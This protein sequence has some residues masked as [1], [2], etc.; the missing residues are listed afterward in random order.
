MV[1]AHCAL[2][3]SLT[4]VALWGRRA[5]A[6]QTLAQTLR[7]EGLPVEAAF[8]L[9]E[10]VQAAD[11]VC[12]ATTSTV[13]IVR[14]AW[15]RDGTH[16]DLVGGFTRAMREADD[17]AIARARIIV[18]TYAGALA[19]AGDLVVPLEAGMMARSQVV[20]ELAEVLR[21]ERPGRTRAGEITVFKSVGTALEDLAAAEL[22]ART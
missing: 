10:A 19:E 5:A 13:P 22:V 17:A 6:A 4:R 16:L 8:D 14:G 3:P 20:A 9:E 7:D 21:G 2:K 18:D 11:L 15:L 1:R 12:C